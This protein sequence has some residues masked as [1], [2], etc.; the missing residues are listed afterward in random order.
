MPT[1]W[2]AD[3]RCAGIR[4]L[5][6]HPG[7]ARTNAVASESLL[8]ALS[9]LA[10]SSRFCSAVRCRRW[11]YASRFSFAKRGQSARRSFGLQLLLV[12][13]WSGL[14]CRRPRPE[15]STARSLSPYVPVA[16]EKIANCTT[17]KWA[18]A[19]PEGQEYLR[20]LDDHWRNLCRRF[21]I[22]CDECA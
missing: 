3:D 19:T 6:Y 2:Q 18:T 5:G 4:I 20:A 11:M 14:G 1:S 16:R 9:S 12:V 21:G 8:R 13:S 7:N 22:N 17:G 15:F 10:I